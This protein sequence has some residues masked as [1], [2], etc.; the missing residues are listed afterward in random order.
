MTTVAF[1]DVSYSIASRGGKRPDP[2][3]WAPNTLAALVVEAHIRGREVSIMPLREIEVA[4]APRHGNEEGVNTYGIVHDLVTDVDVMV[5]HGFL[6]SDQWPLHMVDPDSSRRLSAHVV[7]TLELLRDRVAV[8]MPHKRIP[9]GGLGLS[10]LTSHMEMHL[11]AKADDRNPMNDCI[12]LMHLWAEL[13][14][15]DELLYDHLGKWS[16]KRDMAVMPLD[17]ALR[18]ALITDPRR[19]PPPRHRLAGAMRAPREIEHLSGYAL[20]QSLQFTG[21]IA[22]MRM[23]GRLVDGGA[24]NRQDMDALLRA[25]RLARHPELLWVQ[26]NRALRRAPVTVQL[27]VAEVMDSW[28]SGSLRPQEAIDILEE[29]SKFLGVHPIVR[30]YRD[31]PARG[32]L[33]KP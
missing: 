25:E 2:L 21:P 29:H 4:M 5:G 22:N 16:H 13:L 8:A 30:G 9:Y 7:D 15:S 28:M 31:D 17:D 27:R 19:D 18:S 1:I 33:I 32:F 10:T 6:K 12:R 11:P 3:T 23:R 14:R 24:I 26:G 20:R